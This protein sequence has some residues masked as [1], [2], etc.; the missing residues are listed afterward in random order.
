MGGHVGFPGNDM[1]C[2]VEEPHPR[3]SP[4]CQRR[5]VGSDETAVCR[6]HR[7]A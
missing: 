2:W 4:A 6:G 5:R 3:F 7:K 1:V